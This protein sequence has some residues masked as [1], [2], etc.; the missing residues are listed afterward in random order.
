MT[1]G[2]G[3]QASYGSI[4][5]VAE[6]VNKQLSE[7]YASDLRQAN[8]WLVFALCAGGLGFSALLAIAILVSFRQNGLGVVG[9]VFQL[10]ADG[11]TVFFGKQL[12]D[13]N[14][15][16]RNDREKLS[17]MQETFV[18]IELARTTSDK[19]QD[20]YKGIIILRLSG[21]VK[22]QDIPILNLMAKEEV[23]PLPDTASNPA[24]QS[25]A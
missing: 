23:L 8:K 9:A 22:A 25:R 6:S 17:E 14:K 4:L 13:A 1:L 7:I 19:V 24:N 15:Q 12:F 20:H 11:F 3:G 16:V 2:D 10:L 18:A 5:A 21:L